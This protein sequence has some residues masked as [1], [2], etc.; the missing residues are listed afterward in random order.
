VDKIKRAELKTWSKR[1][2][3]KKAIKSKRITRKESN[4]TTK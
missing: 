2:T 3:I 1:K 4:S